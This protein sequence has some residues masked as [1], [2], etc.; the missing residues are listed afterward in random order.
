M[1]KMATGL[2]QRAGGL[3]RAKSRPGPAGQ[4]VLWCRWGGVECAGSALISVDFD[5]RLSCVVLSAGLCFG[6]EEC[7]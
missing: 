5:V 7:G 1:R 3:A 2:L 4:L 6:Y